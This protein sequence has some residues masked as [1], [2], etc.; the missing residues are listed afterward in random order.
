MATPIPNP[1]PRFL[2]SRDSTG[3]RSQLA[4]ESAVIGGLATEGDRLSKLFN[5]MGE[6]VHIRGRWM[7]GSDDAIASR[8]LTIQKLRL[9]RIK[10]AN[11]HHKLFQGSSEG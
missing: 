2:R 5:L 3:Q 10:Y 6:S 8:Y 4:Y 9:R 7:T 1:V 11:V